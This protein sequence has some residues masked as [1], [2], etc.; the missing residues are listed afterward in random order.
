[1]AKLRVR[2]TDNQWAYGDL[3]LPAGEHDL[4]GLADD[5]LA[6]LGAALASPAG[7]EL[8]EA[9]QATERKL[10]RAVEPD[11]VSLKALAAAQESGAWQEGN[12]RAHEAAQAALG[13]DG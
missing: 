12:L 2:V 3:V 13:G 10:A 8:V 1:M 5:E 9:D 4:D 6:A 11:D 7:V